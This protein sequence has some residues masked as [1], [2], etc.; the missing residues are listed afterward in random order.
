MKSASLLYRYGAA[1]A[2]GLI[3]NGPWCGP[4][5]TI[6]YI[7]RAKEREREKNKELVHNDNKSEMKRRKRKKRHETGA[8]APSA[9]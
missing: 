5:L 7:R 9:C 6:F 4:H 8:T 1:G 3:A 2:F